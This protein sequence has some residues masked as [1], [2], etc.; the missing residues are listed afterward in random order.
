MIA[1]ID[2]T[3]HTAFLLSVPRDLYVN[4]PGDGYSKINATAEFGS[5]DYANNPTYDANGMGLLEQVISK[6][7]GIN[8][9]YYAL[10]DY[11]AFQDAVNSV[12]GITVNIQSSDP[13]GL[14]DASDIS[15]GNS[16]PL[17]D[18]SNGIHTLNGQ[19]A[20]DLARARGDAYGSYGYANSDYTRTQNQRTMII[21]IKTKALSVGVLA[22]PIK[23][24]NLFDS[25]GNNVETDLTL[26]NARTLYDDTK[27][28]PNSSIGSE[29]LNNANGKDLLTGY[30]TSD[31]EDALIPTS[32]IN[33]FSQIQTFISQL[34]GEGN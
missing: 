18:L 27:N 21:A 14:Y 34:T 15:P 24:G 16:A 32:G 2:T 5:S 8:I 6:D 20:L 22:N 30:L 25:F 17:V 4:I 31:G 1:S 33:N 10:V 19:Q 12:G 23:L 7:F 26:G 3:N 13:R 11:S 9:D 28:I 29:S